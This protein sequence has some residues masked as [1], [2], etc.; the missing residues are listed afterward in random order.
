M[1]VQSKLKA[2]RRIKADASAAGPLYGGLGGRVIGCLGVWGLTGGGSWGPI[3]EQN[4]GLED[5][6]GRHGGSG[7]TWRGPEGQKYQF[8]F[9]FWDT[10]E[11]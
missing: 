11:S 5:T 6:G 7:G 3:S 8:W 4:G 2:P 10:F 9:P 1:L